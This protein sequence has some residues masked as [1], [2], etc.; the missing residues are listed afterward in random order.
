MCIPIWIIISAK[1]ILRLIFFQTR[2]RT[3]RG[4]T[5]SGDGVWRRSKRFGASHP[6]IKGRG[7]RRHYQGRYPGFRPDLHPGQ[8]LRAELCGTTRRG[9][10][11]R[12][13][14]RRR[15]IPQRGFHHD[16]LFYQR[17]TITINC[18]RNIQNLLPVNSIYYIVFGYSNNTHILIQQIAMY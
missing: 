16:L 11:I 4:T 9:A 6:G 1:I 14:T 2:F 5:A 3:P 17:D 12:R 18:N 8:T 13:R 10:E 7:H 15:A